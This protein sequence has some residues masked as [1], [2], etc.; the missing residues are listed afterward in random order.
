MPTKATIFHRD[1]IT[2][3]IQY[4]INQKLCI[5]E[6]DGLE[7]EL[8]LAEGKKARQWLEE[9]EMKEGDRTNGMIEEGE[10]KT[11]AK[12]RRNGR[13]SGRHS[14]NRVEAQRSGTE[15]EIRNL[16]I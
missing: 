14:T 1:E 13:H 9:G 2:T 16:D 8:G 12:P 7:G 11:Q 5:P 6:S 15:K 10:E 3:I 4:L